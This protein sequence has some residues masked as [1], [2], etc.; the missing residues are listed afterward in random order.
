MSRAAVAEQGADRL[1]PVLVA[2]EDVVREV[3]EEMFPEIVQRTVP[4]AE[5][6]TVG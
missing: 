3:V 6:P 5:T 4:A 2:R 1:L